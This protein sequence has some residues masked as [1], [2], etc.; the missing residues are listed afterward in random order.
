LEESLKK[1]VED[2]L[3][4]KNVI[5]ITALAM[6]PGAITLKPLNTQAQSTSGQN[7]PARDPKQIEFIR[8][9]QE[10]CSKNDAANGEKCCQLSKELTDKYPN[11][12]KQYIDD[13]KKV[14][15]KCALNKAEQKF[16]NALET[17]YESAPEANKLEA[18][19]SAGDAYLEI[20]KDQQSPAHILTVAQLALAGH[21]AVVMRVYKDLD[22]VK[23]YAERSIQAIGTPNLPEKYKMG[24]AEYDLFDVRDEALANMNQ[25]LGYYLIETKGAEPEAQDQALAYI[26]K[27]IQ[28]RG[29]DSR[30][31]F[32]W[33]DMYNYFL[34]R[35]IYSKR[36]TEL[37]KKYQALTEE[38]KNGD[39]GKELIRQ[40]NQIIDTK[41]IP[42]LAR[43]IAT[44]A[45]NPAMKNDAI[46]HFNMFWKD[47]VEDL[48]E[49]PAYLKS[50]EAD[51]TIEGPP[52]PAKVFFRRDLPRRVRTGNGGDSE[53][54]PV[55][56]PDEGDER[57]GAARVSPET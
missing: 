5:L 32:G 16:T 51:P 11:A 39:T 29:K 1:T 26:N 6:I 44:T 4:M 28:V 10:A 47:R 38:Q 15:R 14:V 17:F 19:F 56:R 48:S 40:T 13:A 37:S 53:N 55:R 35:A 25:Y 21:R 43:I 3:I 31:L 57:S 22:R 33:K 49:A 30:A 45:T 50:F 41:L 27:S 9:W 7:A 2:R 24:Y 42:E 18:L 54:L 8:T 12:E 36:Y 52:V 34:R 23:T 20:D 46:D